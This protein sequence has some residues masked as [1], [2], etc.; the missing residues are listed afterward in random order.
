MLWL[1]KNSPISRGR[2]IE[3][4]KAK[5]G[6]HPV[7]WC[8]VAPVNMT[9]SRR[10]HGTCGSKLA[11]MAFNNLKISALGGLGGPFGA[12]N[13]EAAVHI[14]QGRRGGI[15]DGCHISDADI[16][17]SMGHNLIHGA[18]EGGGAADN[19]PAGLCA[20]SRWR[21][22]DR[23]LRRQIAP[24]SGLPGRLRLRAEHLRKIRGCAQRPDQSGCRI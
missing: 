20:G 12:H 18:F 7:V 16:M 2:Y 21:Q 14:G 19:R 23:A 1:H 24:Q 10:H 6:L 3:N 4:F 8:C 5:D 13:L 15:G 22:N 11:I 17:A 9:P